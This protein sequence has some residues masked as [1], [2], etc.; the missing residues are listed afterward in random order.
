VL[1][2]TRLLAVDGPVVLAVDDAQWLDPTTA[3]VLS[4][5]AAAAPTTR[6]GCWWP[7]HRAGG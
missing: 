7:P 3:G 1:A 4:Y 5:V 2:L 6:S